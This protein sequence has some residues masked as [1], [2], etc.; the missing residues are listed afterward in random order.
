[1]G[2]SHRYL[3]ARYPHFWKL[4]RRLPGTRPRGRVTEQQTCSLHCENRDL[5]LFSDSERVPVT[6]LGTSCWLWLSPRLGSE[7][8]ENSSSPCSAQDSADAE[9][10]LKVF[11]LVGSLPHFIVTS[12]RSCPHDGRGDGDGLCSVHHSS[13]PCQWL[14]SIRKV[15]S[16]TRH[17]KF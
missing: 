13:Q 4:P 10:C 17:G 2:F 1:M 6:P 8:P 7:S 3:A 14:L 12:L 16:A 9:M 15:A 11:S 5:L